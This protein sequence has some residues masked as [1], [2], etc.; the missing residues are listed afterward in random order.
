MLNPSQ[1]LLKPEL[2]PDNACK[3]HADTTPVNGSRPDE[4]TSKDQRDDTRHTLVLT[5]SKGR[6]A[7]YQLG[8]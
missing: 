6:P 2:K 4:S 3:G 1:V 7:G 8:V 5:F